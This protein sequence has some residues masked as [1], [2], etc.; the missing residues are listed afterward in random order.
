MTRT[1]AASPSA[2]LVLVLGA[3]STGKSALCVALAQALQ[4]QGLGATVVTEWL[5]HWCDAHGRTPRADEQ[6]EIAQTQTERMARAMHDARAAALASGHV[7]VV[8][9]D[10]SAW[11][12]AAYSQVIFGDASLWALAHALHRA[13][14]PALTLVTGNDLPWQ[15]DGIQRDGGHLRGPVLRALRQALDGADVPYSTVYGH[16]PARPA[17]ALHAVRAALA[18]AAS[19]GSQDAMQR[20]APKAIS[21]GDSSLFGSDPSSPAGPWVAW[22]RHCGDTDPQCERRLFGPWARTAS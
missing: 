12:T 15:P 8:L 1:G 3:E 19:Q 5:R 10:T 18:R 11:M 16:G 6:A 20:V 17:A 2:H 9:A 21:T 13:V 4:H 7:Q 14:P 22:C